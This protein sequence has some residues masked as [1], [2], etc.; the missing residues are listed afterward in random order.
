MDTPISPIGS[1]EK[2]LTEAALCKWLGAAAPGDS[3]TYHRGALARQICPQLN[4]LPEA[5]RYALQRLAA[6]ARKL[7]ELG[8][9]DLVQR[10]HGFEDY[11]YIIVARRRPRRFDASVLPRL[12]AG[13]A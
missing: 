2:P 6:R 3:I 8:I 4:C 13:A 9:A 1:V 7:A 5:Q 12:L 11:A 10:R